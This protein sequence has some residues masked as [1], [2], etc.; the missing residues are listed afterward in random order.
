[1]SMN[2]DKDS[3]RNTRDEIIDAM[4]GENRELPPPVIFTQTATTSQMDSCG[5][6]WPE[7]NTDP[8]AMI[9]L[10]LQASRRFGFAMARIPYCLTVEAEGFGCVVDMGVRDRQ[11]MVTDS[12]YR[13]VDIPDVPEMPEPGEFVSTGRRKVVL[14]A[15]KRLQ[16]DNGDLFLTSACVAPMIVASHILGAENFLMATIMDPDSVVRWEEAITPC[17]KAYATELSEVSDCVTIVTEGNTDFIHPDMFET[18]VAPST[19]AIVDGVRDAFSVLHCCGNTGPTLGKLASL[20]ADGLSVETDRDPEGVI[21]E[22]RGKVRLFG[23]INP[24][25]GL[26]M[27]SPEDIVRSARRYA[28]LGYDIIAPECGVPP[29]TPDTNMMALSRY[30]EM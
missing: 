11:A 14:D 22:T 23:G 26:M 27:G 10:S 3:N 15:C 6:A 29:Q 13:T 18:F 17:I 24:V 21:R 12:P 30:R 1:M 19:G 7:A 28:D 8:V 4:N 2:H 5:Y 16:R 25:E 20:G 9:E